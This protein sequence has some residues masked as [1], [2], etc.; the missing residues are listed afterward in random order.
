MKDITKKYTNG[1]VTIVW[2]PSL[3]AH[4]TLCWKGRNGLLSV[5]NP[6]EK[7][8]IKPEGADTG[9]IIEQI[10]R[11]PSGALTYVMNEKT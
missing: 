9:R 6:M 3:C 4:S 1:E 10:E 7:P 11:C 8:W 5:F 2:K